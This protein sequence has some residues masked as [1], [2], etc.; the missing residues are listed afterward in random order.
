MDANIQISIVFCEC[1][2]INGNTDFVSKYNFPVAIKITA[3]LNLF[4][5]N[6]FIINSW[7]VDS[8]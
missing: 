2:L 1:D 3:T 6:K 7:N 8:F 4:N 5:I